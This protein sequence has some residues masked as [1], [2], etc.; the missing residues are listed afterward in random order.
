MA[1]LTEKEKAALMNAIED[2]TKRDNT[3]QKCPDC[4]AAIV[5]SEHKSGYNI[6][7]SNGCFSSTFR[8]V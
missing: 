2:F 4:G 1:I 6:G 3:T 5:F 7:C 8:G